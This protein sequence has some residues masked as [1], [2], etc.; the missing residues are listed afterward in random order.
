MP[1]YPL[2]DFLEDVRAF[3]AFAR[4][5]STYGEGTSIE[6]QVAWVFF[7]R[8]QGDL[9]KIEYRAVRFVRI[10]QYLT[11]HDTELDAPGAAY[12]PAKGGAVSLHLL[13][14]L[15]EV[16]GNAQGSSLD[17]EVPV[18]VILEK[19]GNSTGTGPDWEPEMN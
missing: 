9:E 16:Y 5:V 19:V 4:T 15:H 2:A 10:V 3:H 11:A 1:D 18:G 12:V 13:K 14:A 8:Y 7:D 6:G 17:T